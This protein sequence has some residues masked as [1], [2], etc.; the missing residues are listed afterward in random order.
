MREKQCLW[1]RQVDSY[2]DLTETQV[3]ALAI[4]LESGVRLTA[5]STNHKYAFHV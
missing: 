4:K 3:A 2:R 5:K 1:Q